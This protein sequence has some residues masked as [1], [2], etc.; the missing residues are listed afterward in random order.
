MQIQGS[1]GQEIFTN[2]SFGGNLIFK[3]LNFCSSLSIQDDIYFPVK[4]ESSVS[5]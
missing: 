5:I 4:I 1:V 3:M 2:N